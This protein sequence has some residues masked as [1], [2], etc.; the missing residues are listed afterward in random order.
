MTTDFQTLKTLSLPILSEK[1]KGKDRV[2]RTPLT[3]WGELRCSGRVAV[4]VPLV[5]SKPIAVYTS[6][7]EPV[8]E[9]KRPQTGRTLKFPYIMSFRV[10]LWLR[11]GLWCLTQYSKLFQLHRGGQFYCMRK[12]EY[13]EKN[14]RLSASH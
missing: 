14:H 13:P 4:P 2:T 7:V 5:A 11:L 3:T 6:H 1:H 9:S 10:R 12:P 8:N